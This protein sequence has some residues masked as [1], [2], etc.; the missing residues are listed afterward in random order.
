MSENPS[1]GGLIPPKIPPDPPNPPPLLLN[2]SSTASVS[3]SL[4]DSPALNAED[5]GAATQIHEDLAYVRAQKV[6]HDA[7]LMQEPGL[8]PGGCKI[9]NPKRG[10]V[11]IKGLRSKNRAKPI[12]RYS[13]LLSDLRIKGFVEETNRIAAKLNQAH[14]NWASVIAS[15]S[16]NIIQDV[17]SDVDVV[18]HQPL[19][20]QRDDKVSSVEDTCSLMD[21]DVRA[22]G[23]NMG[24][25]KSPPN[26]VQSAG[27]TPAVCT[28]SGKSSGPT[29]LYSGMSIETTPAAHNDNVWNKH[30]TSGLSFAEQIKNNQAES[31]VNLEY[32]PPIITPEGKCRV[33]LTKDDLLLS[34]KAFPLYLYGYFL[35]TSMDFHKVNLCLKRLW[36]AYDI[37]EI[38]KSTAGFYYFKFSSE[39]GLNSVLE[40][41]PWLV[42]NV[43]ILLNRWEPGLCLER[44][45]P[46]TIPI[47]VTVHNVPMELWTGRGMS[48][49]FSDV[50]QPLL[51]DRVTQARVVNNSG[52]LGY[53]RMLV[54]AKAELNLPNEVE[55]EYPSGNDGISRVGNL[56]VTYQWKPAVCKHCM[57]FGH[58]FKLCKNR[59]K[60]AEE[61]A[62]PVNKD[63]SGKAKNNL[64]GADKE[65]T[66]KASK[67]KKSNQLKKGKG[68]MTTGTKVGNTEAE[69][70]NEKT[71]SEKKHQGT[72][73]ETSKPSTSGVK[74]GGGGFNFARAIQGA[75]S[76][77]GMPKTG[78]IP[79]ENQPSVTVSNR[80]SVLDVEASCKTSNLVAEKDD[81]LPKDPFN[82]DTF[83]CSMNQ[84]NT[85]DPGR[86]LPEWCRVNPRENMHKDYG[87]TDIQKQW[88]TDRLLSKAGAV[89]AE[90][91]EDWVEGEWEFFY[92]KCA[93]LG[94]NPDY[95]IE[96]VEED[97]SGSA[98]F[99]ATQLNT[100][101]CSGP[102]SMFRLR[103]YSFC[104]GDWS[105]QVLGAGF[106]YLFGIWFRV[107]Q[108]A[109]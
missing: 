96:D 18:L 69:Q 20:A 11:K 76:P 56:N 65:F 54:N 31:K 6:A 26:I 50:G 39:N 102:G 35:G 109:H 51:L 21:E 48:K 55:V 17:E 28:N 10:A 84:E 107:Y 8:P 93:E 71:T 80:F 63:D 87:I 5:I 52:K 22:A 67:I 105:A 37:S 78:S 49:V 58:S 30:K 34:A 23:Q 95:C 85:F 42:N 16:N 45:E 36:K 15:Q 103:D 27:V 68:S 72:V 59:P 74:K 46:S 62:A 2:S 29:Q 33:V 4:D 14:P 81:Q 82:T 19:P 25:K 38:S 104:F 3:P 99:F 44:I 53:A 98:Q 106:G 1:S 92:D 40:N 89:R 66:A 94:L 13:P 70:P 7:R 90:D 47:W 83:T 9:P 86:I 73:N 60:M 97:M 32:I 75:R 88:I 43:P 77:K 64:M 12:T 100:G 61:I 41:G 101:V 91:Q 108:P 24:I 79:A 57:V